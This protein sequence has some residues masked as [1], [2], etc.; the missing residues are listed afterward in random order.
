MAAGLPTIRSESGPETHIPI[1]ERACVS[2][3]E[4]K[5]ARAAVI[6]VIAAA[7][8]H[9]AAYSGRSPLAALRR[10]LPCQKNWLPRRVRCLLAARGALLFPRFAPGRERAPFCSC[11][12][13][14]AIAA[15][16]LTIR[17][18]S[19]PETHIPIAIRPVVIQIEA[20]KARAAA[21]I[22]SAAAQR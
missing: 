6:V 22:V 9:T 20:K 11:T 10:Q 15:G 1:A 3:I 16:L 17:S 14:A 4:A 2:D 5:K 7:Q 8:R 19:G 21:I 13:P 12:V 18:E